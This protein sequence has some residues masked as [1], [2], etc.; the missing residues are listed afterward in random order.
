VHRYNGCIAFC[1]LVL[2]LYNMYF[3][4]LFMEKPRAPRVWLVGD[5]TRYT[6]AVALSGAGNDA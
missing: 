1:Y 6:Y 5:F 4:L 3:A 2:P